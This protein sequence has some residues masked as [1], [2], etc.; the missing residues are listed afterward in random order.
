MP[1]ILFMDVSA[2]RLPN[3]AALNAV[4][5]LIKC[6]VDTKKISSNYRL[7]GHNQGVNTACPG[8]RLYEEIKEWPNWTA[9]S[10]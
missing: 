9:G 8:K 4:K 5:Q 1:L 10:E 7:K 3:Q 6:G 2:D